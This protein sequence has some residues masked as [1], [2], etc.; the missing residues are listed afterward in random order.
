MS[1]PR[2]TAV[3]KKSARLKSKTGFGRA[4]RFELI[5]SLFVF[6]LSDVGGGQA[7]PHLNA[8]MVRFVIREFKEFREFSV[9]FP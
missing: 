3:E 2:R 6:C 4:D 7:N 8:L 5:I 1:H 9:Y